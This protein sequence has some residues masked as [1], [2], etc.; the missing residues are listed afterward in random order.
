MTDTT[1]AHPMNV[2]GDSLDCSMVRHPV[3]AGTRG[4]R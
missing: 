4:D 1:Q 3:A 2:G